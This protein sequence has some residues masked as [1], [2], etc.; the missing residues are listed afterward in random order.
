MNIKKFFLKNSISWAN[1]KEPRFVDLL[2][3]PACLIDPINDTFLF[4]NA[5]FRELWKREAIPSK[6]TDCFIDQRPKLIVFTQAIESMGSAQTMDLKISGGISDSGTYLIQ[7]STLQVNGQKACLLLIIPESTLTMAQEINSADES[8]R[9]GLLEWRR[10]E[11]LYK[12]TESIN[13]LILNAAGDGIFGIDQHGRT[14][15]MNPAAAATLGW[16]PSDLIGKDMHQ[17]IHHHHLSSEPYAIED[18]PIHKTVTEGSVRRVDNEVFWHKSGKPVHVEYTSTPIDTD[19]KIQGA[20]II[21]RDISSRLETQHAL[22]QA[23]RKV[24]TLKERLEQE[25]EYLRNEVRVAGNHATIIGTSPP[26]NRVIEQIE[27][28]APTTANVLVT[29]ES[30]TGK[31]LVAQAIH[32]ASSRCN[33]P[34]IRVNCA[35]IPKDLF[36]SEFF[37][38]V[39]GAFSGAVNN[40]VGRFELANG[41]TLFLDEVGE[42]PLDLQGKLLRVLQE[43][44]YERVG[45]GVTRQT[46]VRIIAATNRDL[47]LEVERRTFRE[48]LFFR[49]DVFP[50]HCSPLRERIEDIP[51]LANHFIA[52]ACGRSNIPRPKLDAST[53][54][55]LQNYEWPG[56]ARE[57]QNIIERGSI[58][59]QGSSLIFENSIKVGNR[60]D[61]SQPA[62]LHSKGAS[63]L[64]EIATLEKQLIINTLEKCN[65]RVSGPFGAALA[66]GIKAPT[67]YSKIKKFKSELSVIPET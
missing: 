10:I 3:I 43:R 60:I 54:R 53:I 56:N 23:L 61:R 50:I 35:A 20:V 36:E 48:D 45:E 66:L 15:F 14:E 51:L 21:F 27:I 65:G 18:C 63:T 39:K 4:T 47:R 44:K 38:H 30:G 59:A 55:E 25:N 1:F 42:I 11:L 24:D 13:E 62:L 67:L 52:L 64:D 57:L 16:D 17:W 58:L 49:L 12:Q 22:E 26:T 31:E 7:G 9:A 34:L 33:Q 32:D 29:G 2:G 28:V 41:G 5:A 46:D 37:G 19:G 8:L 6:P 40:R